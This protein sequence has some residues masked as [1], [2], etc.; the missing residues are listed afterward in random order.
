MTFLT[1]YLVEIDLPQWPLVNLIY[2]PNGS[3]HVLCGNE[4]KG[5]FTATRTSLRPVAPEVR[6]KVTAQSH[7]TQV[8][9][10]GPRGEEE[11][12]YTSRGGFGALL[13]QDPR[14]GA[15]SAE[16]MEG[17]NTIRRGGGNDTLAA[18]KHRTV[19][20]LAATTATT[21]SSVEASDCELSELRLHMREA[22]NTCMSSVDSEYARAD[23]P[24]SMSRQRPTKRAL[25]ATQRT[26]FQTKSKTSTP[27]PF[28]A[29]PGVHATTATATATSTQAKR[30]SPPKR[31][32]IPRNTKKLRSASA[33][34]EAKAEAA[35]NMALA[36]PPPPPPQQQQQQHADD[37][38]EEEERIREDE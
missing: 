35:V 1:E 22:G 15:V 9:R 17:A 13:V 26:Q 32:L 23:V 6:C 30:K 18:A 7:V 14:R 12:E 33:E 3:V 21:S 8:L 2:Y 19:P 28:S 31:K 29:S 16:D 27:V 37:E 34:V 24:M 4:G 10:R 25:T 20:V 11:I 38:T 36:A 5:M